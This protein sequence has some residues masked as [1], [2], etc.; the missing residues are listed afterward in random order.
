MHNL[1]KIKCVRKNVNINE[2]QNPCDPAVVA[3]SRE[4]G[5]VAQQH[6]K[7]KVSLSQPCK[8]NGDPSKIFISAQALPALPPLLNKQK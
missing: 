3:L 6:S 1:C 2:W 5:N 8:C 4:V 7:E